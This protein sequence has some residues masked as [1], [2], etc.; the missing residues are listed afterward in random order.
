MLSYI[1][2]FQISDMFQQFGLFIG[3]EINFVYAVYCIFYLFVLFALYKLL[4]FFSKK[5]TMRIMLKIFL[6]LHTV[7]LGMY[8]SCLI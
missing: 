6:V 8:V 2:D 7:W 3:N 4:S 1:L 5:K